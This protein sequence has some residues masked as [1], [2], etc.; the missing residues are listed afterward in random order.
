MTLIPL[1]LLRKAAVKERFRVVSAALGATEAEQGGWTIPDGVLR[2]N[3]RDALAEDFLPPYEAFLARN[4]A[5]A[6]RVSDKH[7]KY[8]V[9]VGGDAAITSQAYQA[10]RKSLPS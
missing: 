9:R 1:L 8:T 4:A 5:A 7:I 6:V 10:L 2:A 3:L